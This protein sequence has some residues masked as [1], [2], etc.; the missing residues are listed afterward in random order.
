VF[1]SKLPAIVLAMPQLPATT[2]V[3]I[4][5]KT[6]ASIA[7]S[8]RGEI[9]I[10]DLRFDNQQTY[11]STTPPAW[12]EVRITRDRMMIGTSAVFPLDALL[13]ALAT[14]RTARHLDPLVPI[15][16]LVD[17]D[18]DAQRLVDVLATLAAG[19]VRIV[20]LGRA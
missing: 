6:R 10:L 16:V 14:A 3:D 17:P 20:G 18:I 13:P 4:V 19:R 7:V 2:L 9:R 15:D 1:D 5:A 12:L 8:Y 11:E